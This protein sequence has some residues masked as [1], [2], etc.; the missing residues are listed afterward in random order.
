MRV[1]AVSKYF[2][3]QAVKLTLLEVPKNL[4]TSS[5]YV[6]FGPGSCVSH[7]E[8]I[9]LN[10][11]DSSGSRALEIRRSLWFKCYEP[12]NLTIKVIELHLT[13]HIMN[14]YLLL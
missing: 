2:S 8:V 9:R 5:S 3:V 10:A 4:N 1:H 12:F 6:D 14:N 11:T 13:F 7:N